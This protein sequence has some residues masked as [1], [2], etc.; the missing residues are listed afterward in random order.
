MIKTIISLT[1]IFIIIFSITFIYSPNLHFWKTE[2]QK[3]YDWCKINKPFMNI[4]YNKNVKFCFGEG[5]KDYCRISFPEYCPDNQY[6]DYDRCL[7]NCQTY[8]MEDCPC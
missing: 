3:G 6:S 4:S 8:G 7:R 1:I 5:W 2:Y